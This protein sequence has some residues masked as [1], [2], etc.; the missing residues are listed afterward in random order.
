M[1]LHPAYAREGCAV[2][3]SVIR[4]LL[5]GLVDNLLEAIV[6]SLIQVI[7]HRLKVTESLDE[8]V[9]IIICCC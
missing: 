3:S 9:E 2:F 4:H 8:L 5:H 7:L 1:Y 6:E